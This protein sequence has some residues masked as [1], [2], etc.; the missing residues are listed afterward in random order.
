M[1]CESIIADHLQQQQGSTNNLLHLLHFIFNHLHAC[2]L[3]CVPSRVYTHC[4]PTYVGACSLLCVHKITVIDFSQCIGCDGQMF[5][6]LWPYDVIR[7]WLCQI[8]TIKLK[9][10]SKIHLIPT[11]QSMIASII[12][13]TTAII[14]LFFR[15]PSL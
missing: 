15:K 3:L 1:R 7:T 2:A 14:R 9:L 11:I 6:Y 12:Q 5:T 4:A 10:N 8:Y 13:G